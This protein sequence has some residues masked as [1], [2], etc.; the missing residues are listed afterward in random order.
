MQLKKNLVGVCFIGLCLLFSSCVSQEIAQ[1]GLEGEDT[2][3]L[4]LTF[5]LLATELLLGQF[6]G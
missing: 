6:L 5:Q 1:Y 4:N 3:A 2:I